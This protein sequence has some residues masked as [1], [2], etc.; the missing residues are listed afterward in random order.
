MT[1]FYSSFLIVYIV[2]PGAKDLLRAIWCKKSGGKI[3]FKKKLPLLF[4][5]IIYTQ[6]CSNWV[7]FKNSILKG[8]F[9]LFLKKAY[10]SRWEFL[11]FW[12]LKC[13]FPSNTVSLVFLWGQGVWD[14]SGFQ[15]AK[16]SYADPH[17]CQIAN[18]PVGFFW[19]VLADP[20]VQ[21]LH[22]F[23]PPQPATWH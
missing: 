13:I 17:S 15:Q 23:A 12:P 1:C 8:V 22:I 3:F 11:A 18:Q 6:K 14:C 4:K 20:H 10:F 19:L 2:G 21:L 7:S 9:V 5:V 16:L